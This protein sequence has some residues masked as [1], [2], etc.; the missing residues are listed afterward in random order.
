M[1]FLITSLATS[2]QHVVLAR[3]GALVNV[4][5]VMEEVRFIYGYVPTKI[6]PGVDFFGPLYDKKK[7][8]TTML[9]LSMVKYFSFQS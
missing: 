6:Y 3:A 9:E 2:R 1:A 7:K 5:S 8:V 4:L